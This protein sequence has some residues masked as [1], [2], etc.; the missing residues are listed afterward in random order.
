M[1]SAVLAVWHEAE[2]IAAEQ[3]AARVVPPH[4]RQRL[5]SA[6]VMH[7]QCAAL[8]LAHLADQPRGRS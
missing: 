5:L 1:V 3:R 2:A 6:A 4:L 8:A 7:R